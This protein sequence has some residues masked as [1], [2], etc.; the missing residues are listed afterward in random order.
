MYYRLHLHS[1]IQN[2]KT[3]VTADTLQVQV[4]IVDFEL[5]CQSR[6]LTSEYLTLTVLLTAE[7]CNVILFDI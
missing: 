6:F 2:Y 3:F 7:L 4:F 5:L 1:K